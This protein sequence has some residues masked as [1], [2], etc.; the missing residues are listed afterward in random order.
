MHALRVLQTSGGGDEYCA[1]GRRTEEI[2]EY[3][4]AVSKVEVEA[5]TTSSTC[6]GAGLGPANQWAFIRVLH[7]GMYS[8]ILQ[9]TPFSP[10]LP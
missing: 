1:G 5:A 2:L 3:I 6:G 10:S 7:R 8:R 9:A 4:V